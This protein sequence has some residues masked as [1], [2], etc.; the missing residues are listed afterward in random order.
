[1]VFFFFFFLFAVSL[2]STDGGRY[3]RIDLVCHRLCTQPEQIQL[4]RIL[5]HLFTDEVAL[6]KNV[7]IENETLPSIPAI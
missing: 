1:M 4:I 7:L 3:R 5:H 2:F 6:E